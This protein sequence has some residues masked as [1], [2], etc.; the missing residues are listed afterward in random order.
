MDFLTG[1][2]CGS[3]FPASSRACG[4]SSPPLSLLH[5][6]PSSRRPPRGLG[7]APRGATRAPGA[8][9][10]VPELRTHRPGPAA[11]WPLGE[12]RPGPHYR[13]A[14]SRFL[15]PCPGHPDSCSVKHTSSCQGPEGSSGQRRQP[16][17]PG[18]RPAVTPGSTGVRKS[19]VPCAQV[20]RMP[21]QSVML[22]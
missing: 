15:C 18:A 9:A 4:L 10:G 21:R 7:R 22:S 8:L 19:Q 3:S 20:G 17:P 1:R 12:G 5:P 6:F 14:L 16:P 13:A 11:R 2:P